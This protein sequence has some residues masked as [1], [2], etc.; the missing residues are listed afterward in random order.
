MVLSFLNRNK[1]G[2]ARQVEGLEGM[3]PVGPAA[4]AGLV[5]EDEEAIY[6]FLMPGIHQ[7]MEGSRGQKTS[8]GAWKWMPKG[9]LSMGQVTIRLRAV[10][11]FSR[12]KDGRF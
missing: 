10:T 8:L 5:A 7:T 3:G 4:K 2:E 1:I 12:G 9:I 11:G 6:T